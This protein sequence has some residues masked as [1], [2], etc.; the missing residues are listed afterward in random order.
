[1]MDT[2]S[3]FAIGCLIMALAAVFIGA[4]IGN[5]QLIFAGLAVVAISGITIFILIAIGTRVRR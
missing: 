3:F 2:V 5:P 4:V 1:V